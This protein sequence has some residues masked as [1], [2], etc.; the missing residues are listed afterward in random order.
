LDIEPEMT[1]EAL[2][3][4]MSHCGFGARRLAGAVKIYEQMLAG[5]Y[6]N[7]SPSPARWCRPA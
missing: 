4:G 2:V 1:V 7:F 3:E 5:E 6:T